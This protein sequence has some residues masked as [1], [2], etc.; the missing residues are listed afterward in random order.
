[1]VV[2]VSVVKI[3]ISFFFLLFVPRSW[4]VRRISNYSQAYAAIS[5]ITMLKHPSLLLYEEENIL[6]RPTF[7]M[8]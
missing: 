6:H 5:T 3:L 4:L 1:M 8:R 7:K 2:L